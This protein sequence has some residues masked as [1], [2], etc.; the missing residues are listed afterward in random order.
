MFPL[1]V[2]PKVVILID[3]DRNVVRVASNI[4]PLPEMEVKVL[5]SPHDFAEEALGKTF[6]QPVE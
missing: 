3:D 1:P 2:N 6:N 5:T 4:A